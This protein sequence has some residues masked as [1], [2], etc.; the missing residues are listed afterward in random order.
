MQEFIR[1]LQHLMLCAQSHEYLK[2]KLNFLHVCLNAKLYAV[3]T[4]DA[5]PATYIFP[6]DVCE[7]A[8]IVEGDMIA[9]ATQYAE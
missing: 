9:K 7:F 4:T 2:S 1:V 3:H 8:G 5:Y 6:G